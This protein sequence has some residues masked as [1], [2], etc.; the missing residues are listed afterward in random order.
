M[1]A[2]EEDL[3]DDFAAAEAEGAELMGDELEPKKSS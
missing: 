2:F 3:Y 1:G